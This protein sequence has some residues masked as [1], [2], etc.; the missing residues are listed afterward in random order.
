MMDNYSV[1]RVEYVFNIYSIVRLGCSYI[2]FRLC[3][4]RPACSCDSACS[5]RKSYVIGR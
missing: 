1:C 5:L 3:V 2:K 4:F